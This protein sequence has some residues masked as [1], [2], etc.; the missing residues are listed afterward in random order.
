M[1]A[2]VRS[3][4]HRFALRP[5]LDRNVHRRPRPPFRSVDVGFE[6]THS[7]PILPLS[8]AGG[9]DSKHYLPIS[10][11]GALRHVPVSLN[12]TAGDMRRVHGLNERVSVADFGR[13]VCVFQRLIQMVGGSA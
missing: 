11:G 9:T 2:R 3:F 10:A 12:K 4:F 6:L 13:G 8:R 5:L 1:R 7:C